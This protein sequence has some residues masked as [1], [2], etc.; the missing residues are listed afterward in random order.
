[1]I[2]DGRNGLLAK[3]VKPRS[4]AARLEGFL[5]DGAVREG[6]VERARAEVVAGFGEGAMVAGYERVYGG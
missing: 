1:L 4:I 5:D 3:E 2:E 6:L